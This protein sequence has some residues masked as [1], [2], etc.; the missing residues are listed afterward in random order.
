MPKL[1]PLVFASIQSELSQSQSFALMFGKEGFREDI[2]ISRYDDALPKPY[3]FTLSRNLG[4]RPLNPASYDIS[5]C[6]VVSYIR[7]I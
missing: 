2:I 4:N 3:F 1:A 7:L 5:I 6:V